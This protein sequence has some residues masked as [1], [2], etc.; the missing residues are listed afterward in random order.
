MQRPSALCGC[1]QLD[2]FDSL[3]SHQCMHH[4][5]V[6]GSQVC[7]CRL[8][9]DLPSQPF[10]SVA[11]LNLA[12]LCVSNLSLLCSLQDG[13]PNVCTV[14]NGLPCHMTECL[15][16]FLTRSAETVPGLQFISVA[17]KSLATDVLFFPVSWHWMIW[18]VCL[19]NLGSA[20][21]L[22]DPM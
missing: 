18:V 12:L 7:G 2:P 13:V 14:D 17:A 20:A 19:W 3:E 22:V 15:I 5:C 9:T 16:W 11:L 8:Q 4:L 21:Q 1:F 10:I 6:D